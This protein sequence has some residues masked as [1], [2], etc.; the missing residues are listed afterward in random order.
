MFLGF[1]AL[2][3]INFFTIKYYVDGLERDAMNIDAAGKTRMLSQ[4]IMLL[5]E[6]I[7]DDK[8][9]KNELIEALEEHD[10][11][12]ETFEK[13]GV[14]PGG[15]NYVEPVEN[16]NKQLLNQSLELWDPIYS[17]ALAFIESP[18]SAIEAKQFLNRNRRRLLQK[19]QQFVQSLTNQNKEKVNTL[20][21]V[22]LFF[23]IFNSVCIVLVLFACKK[24]IFQPLKKVAKTA[25]NLSQGEIGTT[26]NYN[27]D[28]ELGKIVQG[29]NH[30]SQNLESSRMFI[31]RIEK[32]ELDSHT[33]EFNE[34]VLKNNSIER[35][36]IKMRDQMKTRQKEDEERQWTTEGLTKFVD[37]LR[38]S[39]DVKKLS[40]N[41][42]S[43]LVEYTDSNQAGIYLLNDTDESNRHLE[44]VSLYAFNTKKFDTKTYRLGEGLI[45]QTFL[46]AKTTYLLDV[47]ENYVSITSGLG[48]ANPQSIL[49]VPLKVE[50]DIY[51]VVE[52]ASFNEYEE[53]H[54]RFVEKLCESIASTLAGVKTNQKTKL[55]LEESQQL[56][57][58]M[59][60]QEEEMR[61][62][63]EELTATQ[64]EMSRKEMSVNVQLEAINESL[65]MAEFSADGALLSSNGK[66]NEVLGYN[67]SSINEAS[68][69][70]L[71]G[72]EALLNELVQGNK[73]SGWL[74][75]K[76]YEGGTIELKSHFTPSVDESGN[77]FKVIEIITQFEKDQSAIIEQQDTFEELREVEEELKMNLEALEITQDQLDKKLNDSQN[78]LDAIK[79]S[80][81]LIVY[82]DKGNIS[83]ISEQAIEEVGN[84]S[85]IEDIFTEPLIFME[86]GKSLD[87]ILKRDDKKIKVEV[88]KLYS[89]N[90]SNAFLAIWT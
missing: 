68:F 71:H 11:I 81:S 89:D 17:N 43:N 2:A 60:A 30:L 10:L 16:V 19:N 32:G 29:I 62:N 74:E 55:L 37:I 51:G 21:Y 87:M 38:A 76:T 5:I 48:D 12:L 78:L 79:L 73:W 65:G 61:Q 18:T 23:L 28:N 39:D 88:K 72:S 26:L 53:Y 31:E 25:E 40:D 59:Q 36:L 83:D 69:M 8:S 27:Y 46:E 54:I 57:E 82:D 35:A 52:L 7:E 58:Q 4:K 86:E 20:F 34:V 50:K 22:L 85:N 49:L 84:A 77:I 33:D 13:G 80:V 1:L 63:M 9:V 70:V 42:L 64:E 6:K 56:T 41:I 45:G 3:M 67:M 66:Y 24:Y 44:L 14:L 15:D 90:N 47:P 75:K